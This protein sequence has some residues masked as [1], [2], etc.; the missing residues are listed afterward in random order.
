MVILG[1]SILQRAD[2]TSIYNSV[3]SLANKL[4]AS[5]NVPPDW[6]TLNIMH[7]VNK[8]DNLPHTNIFAN[9]RMNEHKT[10]K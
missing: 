7:R 4:K 10:K 2:G 9:V 8:L 6:K 3:Y 1:S 5:K